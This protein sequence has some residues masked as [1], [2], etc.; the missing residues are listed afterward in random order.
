MK[1]WTCGSFPQSGSRNAWTW[2]KNVVWATLG[3]FSAM[4]NPNDFLSRLESMDENLLYHYDRRQ[5]NNQWSGGIS[6]HT[7]PKISSVK[8]RWKI[9][10][11]DFLG[12]RRHLPNWLS[13]KR[14]NY[15][16]GVLLISAATIEGHFKGKTSGRG[17]FMHDNGPAQA[18]ATQK[19]LAYMDFEC[20]EHPP[21]PP[22]LAQSDYHLFPGRKNKT[23]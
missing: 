12:S 20:L 1:I 19:K 17:K 7:V 8:M 13:S 10:S 4:S 16:F 15:Q 9:S 6:S 22:D 3:I 11:L 18:L 14:P 2:I 5:N 21:F 23:Y